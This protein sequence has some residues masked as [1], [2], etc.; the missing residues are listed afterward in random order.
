MTGPSGAD[1]HRAG[2]GG[3][4][5]HLGRVTRVLL[6]LVGVTTLGVGLL[7][8]FDPE[9]EDVLRID[10]AIEALGSDYVVLAALGLLAVGLALF[11][12]AAQRVRGV[13]E[14]TP[15]AVEGVLTASYPGATFDRHGGGGLTRFRSA[16]SATDRR[17]RLR[18]AATRATMRAEGCSRTD[19]GR[20]VDEGTWTSD[21]VAAPYLSASGRGV[22][23]GTLPASGVASDGDPADRTVDAILAKATGERSAVPDSDRAGDEGLNGVS[24]RN[25]DRDAAARTDGGVTAEPASESNRPSSVR[26]TGRW[27][28]IAAVTLLAVA[29]GVLAERPSLLLVGALAGTY[30]AYPRLT[31]IPDPD[32]TVR[33]ELDPATPAD[34]DGV[35]VRTT[36]TNEGDAALADVRIVDGVPAMLS[37]VDGS[38]RGATALR[39]GGEVTIRYELRARPGRHAFQPTTVLCRDASG[40]VEI[41]RSLTAASSVECEAELSTVPLRARSGHRPGPLVTDDGGEGIEFHSVEEYQRGDPANRIDWR[42]YA[43]TGELT[44]MTF[45]TEGL[46]E[47]MVCVDARPASYRAADATA[48]H[49]VALAVD[50]AGRIGD[51]LFDANHRVGLAG[52]GRHVCVL[53]TRSG[54]DHASR[55]HQRLATDPAFELDPPA[56]GGTPR[57]GGG[58]ASSRLAGGD[59]A[60]GGGSGAN[61]TAPIDTQLS[62]VRTGFGANTQVVLI[63]PLCDDEA[64]RIAQRFESGGTAVTVVSPDVTTAETAG[65]RL[66]RA[67]RAHRLSVLRNAGVPVVDWTPTQPLSA[68][69][70]AIAGRGR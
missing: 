43:R 29:I 62:R 4:L 67:E 55:F 24:G 70:R 30:A 69:M 36:I 7:V 16:R 68:A 57:R 10:A 49:A 23:S 19:A 51:A 5:A 39:P 8:A 54:R 56:T 65:G 45:R 50:A 41:E 9:R 63:T 31:A 32:L 28:G 60:I 52:F 64:T 27:R 25:S 47:V 18:E 14:A 12:A 44:S 3:L 15:P 21:P 37:V 42:R 48:P 26:W 1:T 22:P 35:S 38:P 17:R 61:G 34:G 33:R 6:L 59:G 11:L 40:S 66:A 53:P 58:T 2:S 20:R 13:S 46:A